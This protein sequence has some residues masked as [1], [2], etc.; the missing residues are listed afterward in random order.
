MKLQ[1][2]LHPNNILTKQCKKI[3]NFNKRHT[4]LAGSMHFHML[5]WKGIGL[6]APQIGYD[7]SIITI[8][9]TSYENGKKLTLFNPEIIES[10]L[11]NSSMKEGCLSYPNTYLDIDRPETVVVKYIDSDFKEQISEFSGITAR[12]IQHEIDHLNGITMDTVYETQAKNKKA[13]TGS[14]ST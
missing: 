11:N 3:E 5:K 2:R 13:S 1:L 7:I 12:A 6:A 9:T 14:S 8:N 4:A 10:S